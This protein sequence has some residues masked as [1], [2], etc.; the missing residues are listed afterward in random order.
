MR[1]C[2]AVYDAV[3]V[4]I[5]SIKYTQWDK[6]DSKR[7]KDKVE[8]ALFYPYN[9]WVNTEIETAPVRQGIKEWNNTLYAYVSSSEW[10]RN[11]KSILQG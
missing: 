6:N 3:N 9:A 1:R 11:Q 10:K 4:V 5:I 7:N 8:S 2:K